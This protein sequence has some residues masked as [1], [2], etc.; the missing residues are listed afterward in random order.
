VNDI[1][2]RQLRYFVAVAEER[3]F[4]RAA[5]RLGMTQPA[6]SRAIRALEESVGV[7]LLVRD[8]RGVRP[9]RAGRALFDE[10]R[11]LDDLVRAAVTRAVRA[12]Q[13]A[14]C[15]RV[16]GRA[17][18]IGA[19]DHLVRTYNMSHPRERPAEAVVADWQ[20]QTDA[21]RDGKV[22][23]GLLRHPFDDR[24]LDSDVLRSEPRVALGSTWHGRAPRPLPTWTASYGTPPHTP[25]RSRRWPVG[26]KL[27][28]TLAGALRSW[29]GGAGAFGQEGG[30]CQPGQ[31]AYVPGQMGLV[32]VPGACRQV[33]QGRLGGAVGQV[34]E[35]LEPHD[36]RQSARLQP[37]VRQDQA[38]QVPCRHAELLGDV[39]DPD[40]PPEAGQSVFDP[41]LP[42]TRVQEGGQLTAPHLVRDPARLAGR[43]QRTERHLEVTELVRGQPER[44]PDGGRAKAQAAK[45]FPTGQ[46]RQLNRRRRPDDGRL[47]FRGDDDIRAGVRQDPLYV[48][49]RAGA[50]LPGALH[51]RMRA[52]RV[53]LTVD[54]P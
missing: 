21:L 35:A 50:L 20:A 25:Q 13:E 47:P 51:Q 9:T 34:E 43:E 32:G 6:L 5:S 45:A 49:V 4:T 18:E 11:D 41:P 38:A 54:R 26:S 14:P 30:G 44:R 27:N 31:D 16:T 28:G 10:A 12:E 37:G 19:L 40:L 46:A 8:Y 24:G 53:V 22:D 29:S 42:Y 52:D 48:P 3:D 33:R 23:V 17:C 2:L 39:T 36:P 1:D 7:P 15:L